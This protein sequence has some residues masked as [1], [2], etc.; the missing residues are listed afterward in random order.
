L[1]P[2]W[3]LRMF[4]CKYHGILALMFGLTAVLAFLLATS[5]TKPEPVQE[6]NHPGGFGS[7]EEAFHVA[8]RVLQDYIPAID[9]GPIRIEAQF[10]AT[11]HSQSKLWTIKGYASCLNN[12]RRS[13]SWTVILSYQ[14]TQD[15][16]VLAKIVTPEFLDSN[17][18][19]I[20]QGPPR[21]QGKLL[22]PDSSSPERQ[23]HPTPP[24]C[25]H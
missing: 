4:S 6:S 24:E 2:L 25:Y 3:C 19:L 18:N 23:R 22:Q 20:H 7:A 14:E 21:A 1:F 8:G 15:W 13:Y 12:E 9:G 11:L 5:Q 10:R 17:G 16:E